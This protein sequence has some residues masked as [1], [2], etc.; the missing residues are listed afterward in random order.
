MRL[1]REITKAL[2]APALKKRLVNLGIQ[3]WP[4]SPEEFASLVRSERKRFAQLISGAG[5][6]KR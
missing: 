2:N 3:P 6:K 1:N 5:I 4:G